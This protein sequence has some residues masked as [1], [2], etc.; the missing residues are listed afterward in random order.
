MASS[1]SDHT[2]MVVKVLQL[3]HR[4]KLFKFF[5]FWTKH[6]D[7]HAIVTQVWESLDEG[8]PMYRLVSKAKNPQRPF[9]V[10]Q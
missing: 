2:H 9:K 4:R 8:F 6:L 1:I 7:F 3:V 10:T 5:D